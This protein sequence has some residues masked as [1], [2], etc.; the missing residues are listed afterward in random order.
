MVRYDSAQIYIDS[1]TTNQDKITAIDNV[2]SALMSTAAGAAS[3]D[4]IT[5]YSLNDGQ[6]IIKTT[7]RGVESIYRAIAAF[8]KLKQM[9]VNRM[10]GRVM[11]MRDKKNFLGRR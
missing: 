5:E 11:V 3:S 6:V 8:E 2:I 7:Y 4:N 9:Y 10:N 1:A